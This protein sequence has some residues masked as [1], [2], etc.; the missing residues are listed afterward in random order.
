VLLQFRHS[1]TKQGR[2]LLEAG[3]ICVLVGVNMQV[4]VTALMV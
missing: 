4:T 2:E 3:L 1:C